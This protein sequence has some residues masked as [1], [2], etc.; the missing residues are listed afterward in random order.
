MNQIFLPIYPR[1]NGIEIGFRLPGKEAAQNYERCRYKDGRRGN[2]PSDMLP[3]A[4]RDGEKVTRD[5][6]F[7][8]IFELFEGLRKSDDLTLDVIGS[9]LVRLAL[10]VDHDESGRLAIPD[11]I[12]SF[13]EAVLPE[14]GGLP[15]VDFLILLDCLAWNEDAKYHTLGYD[16]GSGYGRH[17]NLL[18]YAHLICVLLGRIRLFKFAGTLT[19]PPSGVAPLPFTKSVELYPLLG[20]EV[21][22]L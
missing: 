8:D 4:I 9:I 22:Q 15:I 20:G 5:F 6:S 16:I 13:L 19:R 3:C 1:Q 14:L 10:M 12:S 18:T 2:N 17:N 11:P 21:P 7:E